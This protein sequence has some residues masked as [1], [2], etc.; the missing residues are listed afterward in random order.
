[1]ISFIEITKENFHFFQNS[2]IDIENVSFV[3]PWTLDSFKRELTNRYSY[4]WT[5]T[6]DKEL[7]GYICFWMFAG[8]IHIMN[9]AVHPEMRG[10]GIGKSLL[11]RVIQLGASEGVDKVW[12]EVRPSNIAAIVLYQGEGFREIA[13]RARYYSDTNEDAIVMLLSL[14][15]GGSEVS[16]A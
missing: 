6:A 11:E 5:V 4:L 10:K 16:P 1:M 9:I 13:R 14:H 15:S 3:S 12:L 7:F 8:E 2:I